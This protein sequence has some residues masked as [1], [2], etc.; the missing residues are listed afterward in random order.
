MTGS[1]ELVRFSNQVARAQGFMRRWRVGEQQAGHELGSLIKEFFSDWVDRRLGHF[2]RS[3]RALIKRLLYQELESLH[4]PNASAGV[5][6]PSFLFY[7]FVL[8]RQVFAQI[9]RGIEARA[10]RAGKP[11]RQSEL[12]RLMSLDFEDR[13]ISVLT[14]EKPMAALIRA[15]REGYECINLK[16]ILGMTY[17]EIAAYKNLSVQQVRT[18]IKKATGFMRAR[19]RVAAPAGAGTRGVTS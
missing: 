1:M 15:N 2:E 16:F 14:L 11:N 8:A 13:V 6:E 18:R 10:L 5:R 3:N 4:D 19:L 12:M 9:Y 7:F 17:Q